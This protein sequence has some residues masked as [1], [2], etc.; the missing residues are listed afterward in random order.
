MPHIRDF[1]K[2]TDTA[3]W[4]FSNVLCYVSEDVWSNDG[5]PDFRIIIGGEEID[6]TEFFID[7]AK[8]MDA[9]IEASTEERA[10]AKLNSVFGDLFNEL[11][12]ER[13]DLIDRFRDLLQGNEE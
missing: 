10:V 13:E 11:E 9:Q 7:V 1:D 12:R 5:R 3:R 6:A 2:M 4:L 8:K